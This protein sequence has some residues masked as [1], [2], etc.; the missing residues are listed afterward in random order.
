MAGGALGRRSLQE[1]LD[2]LDALAA[3]GVTEYCQ[4]GRYEDLDG[5]LRSFEP[6]MERAEAYRAR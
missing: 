3:L 5:F 6:M 4:G 1:D 2:R